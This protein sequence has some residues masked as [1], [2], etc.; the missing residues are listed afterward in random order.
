MQGDAAYRRRK[1]A[2]DRATVFDKSGAS[3]GKG[4]PCR[5][6]RSDCTSA[7]PKAAYKTLDKI[8][9][10]CV[11]QGVLMQFF[12]TLLK[13]VGRGGEGEEF[14]RVFRH[15]VMPNFFAPSF[16]QSHTSISIS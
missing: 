3:S 7:T 1:L 11:D 2:R 6:N 5:R 13:V 8:K 4:R 14:V 16:S 12:Y 15:C 10:R 9:T